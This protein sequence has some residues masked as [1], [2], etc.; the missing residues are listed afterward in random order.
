MKRA[1]DAEDTGAGK[2][3]FV[4]EHTALDFANTLNVNNGAPVET[5]HSSG[6]IF[7]WLAL[8]GLI[9]PAEHASFLGDLRSP[10]KQQALLEQIREVRAMWKINLEEL[11]AGKAA[12]PE[13]IELLNRFLSDDLSRLVLVQDA[14]ARKFQVHQKQVSLEPAKKIR[15]L[16]AGSIAQFLASANLP[17]LR[18]CAGEDCVIYFYDTT[19]SHRRQWCSMAIC[20]NR[21]KVAK[22]RAKNGP[23]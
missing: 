7:R 20:G 22:F 19:K 5:L 14:K 9:S 3:L 12:A 10:A 1:S 16:I 8:A 23:K 15:A 6:D 21:H 17:Y 11:I 4:G 13:F 18:R 2:F